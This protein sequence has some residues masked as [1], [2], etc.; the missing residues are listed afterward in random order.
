MGVRLSS[1]LLYGCVCLWKLCVITLY[2]I[3]Y[4]LLWIDIAVFLFCFIFCFLFLSLGESWTH[5]LTL[6]LALTRRG[7]IIWVRAHEWTLQFVTQERRVILPWHVLTEACA[8]F[9]LLLS[10]C[11]L[12]LSLLNAWLDIWC[13]YSSQRATKN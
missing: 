12:S 6:Y 13:K 9:W 1:I 7:D 5:D 4:K 8:L 3:W 2:K 10:H 11:S